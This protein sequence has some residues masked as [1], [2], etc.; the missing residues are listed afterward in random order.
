MKNREIKFRAWNTK[1]LRFDYFDFESRNVHRNLCKEYHIMQYTGLKDIDGKEIYEG[2]II[3]IENEDSPVHCE[4]IFENGSFN[5]RD[6][7]GGYW[8]RQLFHQQ[9]RL[10]IIG[11]I[12]EDENTLI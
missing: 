12:Y 1:M 5:L 11:N 3:E 7:A 4:C 2:D 8:T 10:K 6:N 9:E